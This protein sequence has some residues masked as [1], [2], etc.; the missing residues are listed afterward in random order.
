MTSRIL[1][2]GGAGFIGSNIVAALSDQGKSVVVCD[3]LED[4]EKWKNLAKHVISDFVNPDELEGWLE[5]NGKG[6]QAIIHMGAISATTES[7]GDLILKRNFKPTL[8]LWNWATA[9]KTPFIYASSAATYGDGGAGFDDTET[10]DALQN[11]HPLNLYGWSKHAFDKYVARE[12]ASGAMTPPQWAGLKFF[13][14][15]GPNEYHKGSMKS[16]IAQSYPRIAAGEAVTLFKSHNP[17]YEDGG[18]LR[19]FVYVKDCVSVILW[20]LDNR[21]ISG[22][23]NLG[24]GK[25]RSFKDLASAVFAA[26]GQQEDISYRDTPIEI[27]DKYQYFT[28]ANMQKL[29]AAGFGGNFHS[30]EDGIMDYVTEHLAKDD[31]YR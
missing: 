6:L 9:H 7:D 31:P 21:D 19:D 2:T 16:V 20:L 11:L 1:V 3:W 24:T 29:R 23:F 26:A 30:L 8:M 12:I 10:E 14:V 22:L 4:G 28:E 15:Y 27:R 13:N 5:S 25:A 17:D 18:Q